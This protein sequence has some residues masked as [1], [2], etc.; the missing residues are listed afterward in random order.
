[1]YSSS[2]GAAL[3]STSVVS[4]Q[5]HISQT[6]YPVSSGMRARSFFFL[7]SGRLFTLSFVSCV[8]RHFIIHRS[9]V[10]VESR[11]G[12][13]LWC[14]AYPDLC[15]TLPSLSLIIVISMALFWYLWY[16]EWLCSD[17]FDILNG[18]VLILVIFWLASFWYLW[19]SEWP[20]SDFCDI[21]NGLVLILLTFWMAL[22]W[23]LWYPG[24]SH[25]DSCKILSRRVLWIEPMH[26]EEA[27]RNK[28]LTNHAAELILNRKMTDS[29]LRGWQK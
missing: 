23:F 27:S 18:L 4:L 29:P 25:S 14:P 21:L 16:S 1:M 17:T 5:I 7:Q 19:Y 24:Q 13:S 12:W 26:D 6:T 20:H 11:L 28:Q 8:V 10:L 22:F 9:L 3:Q 2:R 15:V